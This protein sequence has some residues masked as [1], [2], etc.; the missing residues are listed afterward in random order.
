MATLLT[1]T[2][3]TID[4]LLLRALF[5]GPLTNPSVLKV[6][7]KTGLKITTVVLCFNNSLDVIAS[8]PVDN[9]LTIVV[10]TFDNTT[11]VLKLVVCFS[12]GIGGGIVLLVV[13]VVVN[14]LT[15]SLVSILGCCTSA[16]GIRTFIV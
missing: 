14:C 6:D 7:S 12:T 9:C 3:L 8:L 15:S 5:E 16:S 11:Y 10:T 2:S 1:N 4:K 13:N